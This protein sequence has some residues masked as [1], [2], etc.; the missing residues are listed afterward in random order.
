M[1]GVDDT[2]M[3][4]SLG[5]AVLTISD[6]RSSEDDRSGRALVGHISDAGHTLSSRAIVR[7]EISAISETVLR[8]V[9]QPKI[10]VVVTTGGTGL[11]GRDVTIEAIAP[12]FDKTLDGFSALFHR[13]SFESVGLSTLQSRACA[14]LIGTTFVFCLPGSSGAVIEAWDHILRDALD[15]R[16]RPCSLVDLMPRLSE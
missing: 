9:S 12:L 14:G 13:M 2:L 15:S 16:Y 6:T 7:D 4:R 11:T 1:P 5:I 3:F 8:W 10:D